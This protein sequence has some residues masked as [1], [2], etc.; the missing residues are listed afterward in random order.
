VYDVETGTLL[1]EH[2]LGEVYKPGLRFSPNSKTIAVWNVWGATVQ[3][4]DAE[5][6]AQP[7]KLVAASA[8]PTCVAFSPNSA[9]LV[10]GYQ[11]GTALVWDLTKK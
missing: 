1:A 8:Q 7:R 3:V 4:C 9:S 11:D 5:G 6:Q 10:V 2:D